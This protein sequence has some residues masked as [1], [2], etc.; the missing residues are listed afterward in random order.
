M[1]KAKKLPSG[2]W[3]IQACYT[4]ATG[5]H[6]K[7]FTA[8]TKKEAEYLAANFLLTGKEDSDPINKTLDECIGL[9]IKA[10]NNVLSPSTIAGYNQ[11]HRNSFKTLQ[12]YRISA[13]TNY[14]MQKAINEEAKK[15]SPKTVAN[16]YCLVV[17]VIKFFIPDKVFNVTLPK[18][19]QPQYNT[20]SPAELSLILEAVKGTTSE[21]PVLLAAFSSLR[22]SEIA[23]LKWKDWQENQLIINKA[24]V[25]GDNGVIY[26]KMT[27]TAAGTRIV[28]LPQITVSCLESMQRGN[29]E[30][31]IINTPAH[32]ISKR[33]VT[34]CKRNGIIPCKFHE[35]RHAFASI[36]LLN[37]IPDKVT[38][39][40]GGWK[41]L[42]VVKHI[43]QQTFEEQAEEAVNKMDLFIDQIRVQNR[44]QND[45]NSVKN[46][47]FN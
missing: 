4:D 47:L 16:A 44:V 38:M 30:E 10:K 22:A 19:K 35:L 21:L 23:A 20:P 26:E 13:I 27:K 36:C 31:R 43:Y 34:V 40:Q 32:N 15:H 29:D 2:N 5:T 12:D 3:R 18:K 42:N 46:T 28:T 14:D 7:S 45:Y 37:G 11:I 41:T 33:F 25:R 8:A 17:T 1:A 39:E 6:R 24:L 9:Y